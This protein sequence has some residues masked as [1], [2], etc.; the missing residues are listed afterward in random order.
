MTNEEYKNNFTKL[1][2]ILESLGVVVTLSPNGDNGFVPSTKTIIINSKQQIKSK[3][4][5]TLHEAGHFTLRSKPNFKERYSGIVVGEATTKSKRIEV[6]FEEPL[7]WHE[8]WNFADFHKLK[9][10][11][12]DWNFYSTKYIGQYAL[13]VVNPNAFNCE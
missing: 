6:L 3:Y 2:E 13:W 4:Y 5:T 12:K 11:R 7:A 8:A 1:V 9:T 10:D